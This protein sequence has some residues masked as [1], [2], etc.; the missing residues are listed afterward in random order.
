MKFSFK[1]TETG[2]K[3][4]AVFVAQLVREGV[5][6]KVCQDDFEVIVTLTGGF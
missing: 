3:N 1:T 4:L 2:Y 5:V 6:F